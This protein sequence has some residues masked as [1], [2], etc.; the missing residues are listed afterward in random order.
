[1]YVCVCITIYIE[2]MQQKMKTNDK[3]TAGEEPCVYT[4]Q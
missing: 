3:T 4:F 2:F 1:M